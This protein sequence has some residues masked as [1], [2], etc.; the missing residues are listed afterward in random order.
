M[1]IGGP[2]GQSAAAKTSRGWCG[3]SPRPVRP[4]ARRAAAPRRRS[5]AG[6]RRGSVRAR[7]RRARR[8]N[9]SAAQEA[10]SRTCDEGAP[11]RPLRLL[12]RGEVEDDAQ[13]GVHA[14]GRVP[15]RD[16]GLEA[17]EDGG[18]VAHLLHDGVAHAF[19]GGDFGDALR[20]D[21]VVAVVDQVLE[22]APHHLVLAP[23]EQRLRTAT[24]REDAAVDRGGDQCVAE[25]GVGVG[26]HG[27]FLRG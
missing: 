22:R 20:V 15:Q 9:G 11:D 18:V 7:R 5:P 14:A 23:A 6:T 27:R 26:G 24:P 19:A 10:A 3:R 12:H 8:P 21:R 1:R 4:A 25:G 2:D 13:H 16:H 17:G